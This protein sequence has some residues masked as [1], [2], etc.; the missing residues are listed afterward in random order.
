ML[1]KSI[2]VFILSLQARTISSWDSWRYFDLLHLVSILQEAI[3][4]WGVHVF[5]G[6]L[7]AAAD[8]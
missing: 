3:R 4:T 2:I 5:D 6:V 1:L 8:L 7:R